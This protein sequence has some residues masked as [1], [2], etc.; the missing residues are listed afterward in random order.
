ME[1]TKDQKRLI[2]INTANRDIKE[3]FVQWA[4]DDNKKI[5]C[6][7]LSFDEA[8]KILVHIGQ[9]PHKLA[10]RAK[11]D[12]TNPRHKY[13]LSLCIQRGMSH[14][15]GKYGY[16]AD[17]DA[18]NEWMHSNKCPVQKRLMDMD[19]DELSTFI[20]ALEGMTLSKYK[21]PKTAKK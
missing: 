21:K 5:S 1:A 4:T 12:K 18:L 10:F 9:K 15:S 17:L 19:N 11:F 13:I 7:D 6:D 20:G 3:E 14:R 2:H 8:N 16:I